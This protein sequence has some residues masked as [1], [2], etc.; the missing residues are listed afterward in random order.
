MDKTEIVNLMDQI[1][2]FDDF[3]QEDKEKLAAL[4]EGIVEYNPGEIIIHQGDLDQTIFVLIKGDI[5]I[6]KND[7]PNS[8]LNSLAPGAVFG[9]VPLIT[10]A[11]RSTN[12]AAKTHVVALKLDGR[13]FHELDPEILNK[14]KDHLLKLLIRRLNEMNASLSRIKRD[15][16]DQRD[17]FNKVK[18]EIDNIVTASERIKANRQMFTGFLDD[19]RGG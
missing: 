4:E 13:L 12:A 11:P 3:R 14:F 18:E 9:E 19:I 10:G 15:F 2:F 5:S 1:V 7:A 8:E 17:S 6:Y 16:N